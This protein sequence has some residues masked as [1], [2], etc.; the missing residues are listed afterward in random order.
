MLT[1]VGAWETVSPTWQETW[2]AIPSWH[3]A[4]ALSSWLVAR[5]VQLAI[6]RLGRPDAILFTLPWYANV[7]EG[8]SVPTRVYYAH[9]TFRFY[10]W[11][12]HTVVALEA[13]LLTNC[14]VGFGVAQ[15]VVEDLNELATTPVHYL[16]MATDWPYRPAQSEPAAS[17]DLREL[18]S[19]R[20]GCVGQISETAYD[21]DLMEY[22]SDSFPQA[23]FVFIGPLMPAADKAKRLVALFNRQNVH[24]LGPK[25]HSLVPIYVRGFDVCINPLRVSEHNHRRS[26]LRLFDYLATDRPIISTA[27]AEA[28]RHVPYISIAT[29]KEDFRRLLAD[30]LALKFAPDLEDRYAYI[31]ANSWDCRATEFLQRV[32]ASVVRPSAVPL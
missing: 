23:Q 7:A 25:P 1:K 13:R 11:N 8:C 28:Y 21:W 9:D 5:Q 26:P 10:G 29:H 12:S 14:S 27:I 16:P 18:A 30:A 2:V 20:V 19:P 15:R 32:G 6:R 4:F 22:L 24:W 3:R 31:A 17:T